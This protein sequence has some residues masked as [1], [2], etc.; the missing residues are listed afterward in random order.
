MSLLAPVG[1]GDQSG[2]SE[3]CPAPQPDF[4][5]YIQQAK[6]SGG[7]GAGSGGSPGEIQEQVLPKLPAAPPGQ[8][9]SLPPG[10]NLANGGSVQLRSGNRLQV[11]ANG[12]NYYVNLNP[13]MDYSHVS[14]KLNPDGTVTTRTGLS[15][16]LT[17]DQGLPP[18]LRA[19]AATAAS[20]LE[21]TFTNTVTLNFGAGWGQVDGLGVPQSDNASSL[22][23]FAPQTYTYDQVVGALKSHALSTNQRQADAY[24]PGSDP[25]HGGTFDLTMAQAKALGLVAPNSEGGVNPENLNAPANLDGWIGF[26]NPDGVLFIGERPYSYAGVTQND[27]A[28][29]AVHE[30]TELMGRTAGLNTPHWGVN[31]DQ[32]TSYSPMDLYRYSSQ[33]QLDLTATSPTGKAYFSTDGGATSTGYWN[34]DPNNGEDLGDWQTAP[35]GH[36][37]GPTPFDALN[38]LVPPGITPSTSPGDTILMNVLGWDAPGLSVGAPAAPAGN[39]APNEVEAAVYSAAAADI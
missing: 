11:T 16:N 12:Q 33:G 26:P 13:A 39:A 17:F 28:N 3:N 14:F 37:S 5:H 23:A 31:G 7:N 27:E 35:N 34:A 6:A 30:F 32:T 18:N 38:A 20:R 15:I 9:F 36:G 1:C 22:A 29:L 10:V 21:G 8:I 24:L 4:A 25:T 2:N 19:A